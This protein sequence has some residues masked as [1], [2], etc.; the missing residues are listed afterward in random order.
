M[1]TQSVV[2]AIRVLEAVSAQQPVGLSDLARGLG[3][4]KATI[5]RMLT[6]LKELDWVAQEGAPTFTWSLTFHAY[7]VGSKGGSGT[8]LR[9]IALGPMSDLQLDTTE[10]VHLCVPVGRSLVVVERLDTPHVLRAFLALGTQ[11]PLNAS[12]TGLAFLAASPDSFIED[13]LAGPLEQR[14]SHTKTEREALW[15]EIATIRQRGYSINEGG[16]SDGIT[17]VGS[18]IVDGMGHPIGSVSVSG[19]AIRIGPE[20][21]LEFGEAVAR[22]AR[23]IGARARTRS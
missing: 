18:A 15:E 22:T 23:D 2:T 20:R 6:T 1:S 12:A 17:S 9:E 13:Y 4:S 16:L 3:Q 8:T 5:L 10:T 19:P 7:A 21:F 11:V 14:T